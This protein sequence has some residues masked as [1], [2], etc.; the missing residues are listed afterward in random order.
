[1]AA[2]ILLSHMQFR[3]HI[4]ARDCN[5]PL[6]CLVP[7]APVGYRGYLTLLIAAEHAEVVLSAWSITLFLFVVTKP[8]ML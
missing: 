2:W 8:D 3:R 4:A 6:Q 1:M 7:W 5:D